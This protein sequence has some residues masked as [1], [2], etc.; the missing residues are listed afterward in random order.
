[1]SIYKYTSMYKLSVLYNKYPIVTRF[2]TN[3][4]QGLISYFKLYPVITMFPII[5]RFNVNHCSLVG[6]KKIIQCEPVSNSSRSF[7]TYY[8]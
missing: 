8:S 7:N 4:K 6:V 2:C 3:K 1:M 5:T